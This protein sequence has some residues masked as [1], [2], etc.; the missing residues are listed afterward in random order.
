M[1]TKQCQQL[2][3]QSHHKLVVRRARR[4]TRRRERRTDSSA[5][6]ILAPAVGV[7]E[8]IIL[9]D[10]GLEGLGWVVG[11]VVGGVFPVPVV[12]VVVVGGDIGIPGE[13]DQ[14]QEEITC[15]LLL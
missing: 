9:V 5:E 7:G 1:E 13:R 4:V 6:N 11:G 15:M 8:A 12:I 10:D 14:D 3:K 2:L